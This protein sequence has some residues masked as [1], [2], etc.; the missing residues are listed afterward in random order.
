M[1]R[2]V[3]ILFPLLLR[4]F[5]ALSSHNA[6]FRSR[7]RFSALFPA[8]CL[9]SSSRKQTSNTQC[10]ELIPI[11]KAEPVLIGKAEPLASTE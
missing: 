11:G 2:R 8:Q 4:L 10:S 5:S 9:W 7:P 1:R 3:L 6:S